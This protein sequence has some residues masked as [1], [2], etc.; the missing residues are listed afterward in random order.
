MQ[1][2]GQVTPRHAGDKSNHRR[3]AYFALEDGH[4]WFLIPDDLDM[5]ADLDMGGDTEENSDVDSD[6][7]ADP[8][9]DVID[10]TVYMC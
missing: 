3:K 5:G 4:W 8:D 10:K 1:V 7:D 6:N 9:P 2:H